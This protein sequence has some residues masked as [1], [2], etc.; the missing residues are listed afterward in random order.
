[1]AL[2]MTRTRT[3]TTPTK[4][5]T[6]VAN[7]HGELEFVEGLLAEVEAADA[8]EVVASAQSAASRKKLTQEQLAALQARKAVLE[9]K[10]QALYLALRQFDADIDPGTIA[11]SEEWT[12]GRHP[13]NAALKGIDSSAHSVCLQ[14]C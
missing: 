1:M 9:E 5:A 10:R 12:K 6:M 11:P 4:L 3:Q 14:G 8:A 7:V 13:C 2:T